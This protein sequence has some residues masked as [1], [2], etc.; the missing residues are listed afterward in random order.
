MSSENDL[1][2]QPD[3][4]QQ[5]PPRSFKP[6]IW[7]LIFIPLVAVN[8]IFFISVGMTLSQTAGGVSG[9]ALLPVLLPLAIIDFL[10]VF[11]Y[12]RK[13]HPQGIARI[14]SY[15]ALILI[16]LYLVQLAIVILLIA[17]PVVMNFAGL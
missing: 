12:I 2:H 6:V 15:T 16:T 4:F 1:P 5:Q 11:F 3:T 8:V 9:F 14:T 7:K 13:Q 17:L 10:A